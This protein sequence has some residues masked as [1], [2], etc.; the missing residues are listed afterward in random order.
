MKIVPRGLNSKTSKTFS[1]GYSKEP[2]FQNSEY[3]GH[4]V[5]PK[6]LGSQVLWS[7]LKLPTPLTVICTTQITVN[8]GGDGV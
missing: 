5:G 6:D 3:A 4:R 1:R 7:R 2:E 8:G